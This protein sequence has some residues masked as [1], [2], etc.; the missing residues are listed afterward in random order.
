MQKVIVVVIALAFMATLAFAQEATDPKVMKAHKEQQMRQ[1][2]EQNKT[3]QPSE[4][5]PGIL[6][7][8]EGDR[9]RVVLYARIKAL[10]DGVGDVKVWLTTNKNLD[11][12]GL[13]KTIPKDWVGDPKDLRAAER[14]FKIR[15]AELSTP[16]PPPH[17]PVVQ[18]ADAPKGE[19]EKTDK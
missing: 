11:A 4:A 17:P 13:L 16:P 1:A 19:T 3:N 18:P 7:V 2:A 15:Q 12:A 5:L 14:R 6:N 9:G 10:D 8:P